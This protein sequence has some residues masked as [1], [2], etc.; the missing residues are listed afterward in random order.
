VSIPLNTVIECNSSA[1]K[2]EVKKH[3][4]YKIELTDDGQNEPSKDGGG[5]P[6]FPG[7]KDGAGHGEAHGSDGANSGGSSVATILSSQDLAVRKR[8]T[9]AAPRFITEEEINNPHSH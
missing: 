3:F 2:C 5:A 6:A 7:D 4:L 8:S 1:F 9:S